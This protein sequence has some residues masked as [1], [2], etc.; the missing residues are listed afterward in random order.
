MSSDSDEK[1]GAPSPDFEGDR[2]RAG[3]EN[4]RQ[5]SEVGRLE[6]L[7]E[8]QAK[9][10][11]SAHEALDLKDE[12]LA[13]VS[14]DLRN[15]LNAIALN[16]QL[17]ERLFSSADPRLG[18]IS[19]SLAS[20]IAQMKRIISDL[21]D[22]AAIEAGKLSVQMQP[23]DARKPIEEAVQ[24]FPSGRTVRSITLD[25]RIPPDPLPACFDPGRIVQVL[26]NLIDNAS[27]FT[28]DGGRILIEGR[29]AD[30]IEI[31]VRDTG[32]GLR[33]EEI[34]V[35]FERFQQVEKRGRRALGLGLYISR[36]IVESHGGR[37]WA[38][39]VPGEGSTFLFTLPP[40]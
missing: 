1:R 20:S 25:A 37:I 7:L 4:A 12:F 13:I 16:T 8:Q 32:P 33:P 38:E 15:P 2:R 35:I 5:R 28:P 39:S 40:A 31:L 21:L 17:L 30:Q 22:L 11:L 36:S 26:E 14:H 19:R 24:T 27:K 23:G 18:R 34:S 10:L 6:G 9:E 29:R 3:P